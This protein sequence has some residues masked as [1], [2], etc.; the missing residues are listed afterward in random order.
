M[1]YG[2]YG[3]LMTGSGSAVYGIFDSFEYAAVACT[4]LKDSHPQVFIAK[5]V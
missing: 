2:A 5:T 4:M 1:T 3:T